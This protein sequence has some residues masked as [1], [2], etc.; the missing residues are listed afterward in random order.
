MTE[1]SPET[2]SE[3]HV[4]LKSLSPGMRLER[5]SP[6]FESRGFRSRRSLK[7]VKTD[8]L[9]IFF[10]SPNKLLL[11]EK[12]V[13]EDELKKITE[14]Q[15][16]N[17]SKL[18]PK[19]LELAQP[20]TSACSQEWQYQPNLRQN[21]DSTAS[22]L[23]RRAIEHTENLQV[24]SVQV[25]SAK[26]QLGDKRKAFESMSD[27][28][29]N[30]KACGICH[31]PGHNRSRCRGNPCVDVNICKLPDKHPEL[32]NE[33]R[34]LQKELKELER[35]YN[36]TKSD[37]EVFLASRQRVKSSFFSVMR[38]RLKKQNL[39]KYVDRYALDK[40]L[41]ILQRAL[42]NQVP[43]NEDLDWR[44]P[45]IIE[46]YTRTVDTYRNSFAQPATFQP[47][48]GFV[49]PSYGSSTSQQ[50]GYYGHS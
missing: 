30:R 44:L 37:N 34:E 36:K 15:P 7:Y 40:D 18:Q 22:P 20:G 23:D 1:Q 42:S 8:D 32:Q 35:K 9:D 33:I 2:K 11:A 47:S 21:Y 6:Q 48:Q 29:R 27:K 25:E 14:D 13:L 24:L 4:W 46:E 49:F 5:L 10:P 45:S 17:V 39:P 28:V 41:L 3:V 16:S 19:K 50:Y 31:G 12:R 38:P 43:L 26:Q